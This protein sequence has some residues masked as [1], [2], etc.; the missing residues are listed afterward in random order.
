MEKEKVCEE[1]SLEKAVGVVSSSVSTALLV[2]VDHDIITMSHDQETL[3]PSVDILTG[4]V[5][6]LIP[7]KLSAQQ[8]KHQTTDL[9]QQSQSQ[10][11]F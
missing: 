2:D 6:I 11:L 4:E 1:P 3:P 5:D 10:E 8:N 9:D 7:E